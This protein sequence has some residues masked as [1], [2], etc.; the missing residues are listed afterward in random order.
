ML[1]DSPHDQGAKIR[2]TYIAFAH[3]EKKRLEGEVAKLAEEIVTKEKEVKILQGKF[4]IGCKTITILLIGGPDIAD[5]A[6]SLSQAALEQKKQSRQ[7]S[8]TQL[9]S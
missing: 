5:R 7:L 3:K 2:S 8:L 4:V 1:L 6:E 9:I